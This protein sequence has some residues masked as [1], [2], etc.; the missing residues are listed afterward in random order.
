MYLGKPIGTRPD[1]HLP[2]ELSKS[3][4]GISRLFYINTRELVQARL[5]FDRYRDEGDPK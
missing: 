4:A 5:Y 2:G 3:Q 1:E